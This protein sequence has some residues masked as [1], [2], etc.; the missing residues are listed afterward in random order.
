MLY[1]KDIKMNNG[2]E[3]HPKKVKV[4]LRYDLPWNKF[5]QKFPQTIQQFLNTPTVARY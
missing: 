3:K 5:L 1:H 2:N 4:K